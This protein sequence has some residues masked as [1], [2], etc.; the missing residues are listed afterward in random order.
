MKNDLR[1]FRELLANKNFSI[2][3]L[4]FQL[5]SFGP[6]MAM[7]ALWSQ[8]A[9]LSGNNPMA[10]GLATIL[11]VLPGILVAPLAG[12]MADRMSK[13]KILFICYFLQAMVVAG[14]F[15]SSELWHLYALATLHS[16]IG[17][18]LTPTHR[19]VL[20]QLVEPEQYV[21]MNAFLATM[22]NILQLFRPA[23]AGFIVAAFGYKTGY[24]VDFFTYF[25]PMIALLFVRVKELPPEQK[26]EERTG[27]WQGVREGVAYIRTE[28]ILIYL[29][30]F[31]M[32]F[33]LCMGMQGPLVY[34]FA[35][36][37]LGSPADASQNVGMLF[38]VLGVGGI[39]GALITPK[40]VKKVSMLLLL[41]ATLAFDGLAVLVF[42]QASTM[43]VALICFALFGLIMS[44]TNIVQD[45][46][47]QTIV[48]ANMRGRVYGA[49]APIT[50]PI[51][52]LSMG[53]GTSLAAV[54]GTRTMF[55][56]AGVME[57]G[58]AGVCRVLPSYQQV[59]ASLLE[60]MG[61]EASR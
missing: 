45:T 57:I 61:V 2:Y 17:A 54:I 58:A 24:A 51:T 52:I 15:F 26:M 56:I 19:A 30:V 8:A 38:S 5:A 11:E 50:G 6:A 14:M 9:L 48:P 59:R 27:A 10:L 32:L 7:F 22:S 21:T 43:L 49:L 53:A 25:I 42:S 18:F 33:T 44:V 55:L 40:L 39:L 60:K 31:Q 35:G 46:I 23:L 28:P 12:W 20:P 29:F 16:T 47:I 34:I 3:A 37:F 41:F 36:E 13:R 1:A 4:S